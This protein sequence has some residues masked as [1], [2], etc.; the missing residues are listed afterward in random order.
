LDRRRRGRGEHA[1]HVIGGAATDATDFHGSLRCQPSFHAGDS[2]CLSK[3]A[4]A[5]FL[6][7]GGLR[8]VP[9]VPGTQYQFLKMRA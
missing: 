3:R 2:A 5:A 1:R 9:G 8:G 7:P 6:D 4:G